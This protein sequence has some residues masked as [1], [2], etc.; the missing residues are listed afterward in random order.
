MPPP[1]LEFNDNERDIGSPSSIEIVA[2]ETEEYEPKFKQHQEDLKHM[3]KI[4]VSDENELHS[5]EVKEKMYDYAVN[6]LQQ[7]RPFSLNYFINEKLLSSQDIKDKD[8]P[9]LES[10]ALKILE[11]L[12]STAMLTETKNLFLDTGIVT[13]Q[14]LKTV[15]TLH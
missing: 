10:Y 9:M 3:F 12:R 8:L 5:R 2:P 11:K 6:D 13:E 1:S 15:T 7:G 4:E 14:D